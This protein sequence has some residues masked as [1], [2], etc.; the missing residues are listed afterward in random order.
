MQV[1]SNLDKAIKGDGF[2]RCGYSSVEAEVRQWVT[3]SVT[4]SKCQKSANGDGATIG[5]ARSLLRQAVRNWARI[6]LGGK[7]LIYCQQCADPIIK[8]YFGA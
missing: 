1:D 4:C 3:L 6:K 7:E 8:T 5:K 2:S